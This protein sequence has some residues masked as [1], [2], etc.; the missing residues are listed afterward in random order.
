[1]ITGESCIIRFIFHIKLVSA[2]QFHVQRWR[3]CQDE[4]MKDDEVDRA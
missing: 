4:E 1:M 3:R 2:M